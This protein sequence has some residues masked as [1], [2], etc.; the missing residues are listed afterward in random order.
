MKAFTMNHKEIALMKQLQQALE[1]NPKLAE[2]LRDA[3]IEAETLWDHENPTY[4]LDSPY[5]KTDQ[6]VASILKSHVDSYLNETGHMV[7]QTIEHWERYSLDAMLRLLWRMRH[8]DG[9]L[10]FMRANAGIDEPP[11]PWR[12][13]TRWEQ[14]DYVLRCYDVEHRNFMYMVLSEDKNRLTRGTFFKE[15]KEFLNISCGAVWISTTSKHSIMEV[16]R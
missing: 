1:E 2:T 13:E 8:R 7:T 12:V 10:I 9:D 11:I 16:D 5:A 14:G 6:D 4:V 3:G 15:M